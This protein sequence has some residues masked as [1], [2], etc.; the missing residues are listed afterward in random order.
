LKEIFSFM[1]LSSER[2]S[3]IASASLD[4]LEETGVIVKNT[5]AAFFLKEA[6]CTIASGRIL[7]PR[8]LVKECI[9]KVP[10]TF[11][12]FTREG[13]R[14]D[15]VGQDEIIFNPGSAAAYIKN[16]QGRDIRK[17]TLQDMEDLVRVVNHLKYMRAQSTAVIP[18]NVPEHVA[19]LSRLHVI[20]RLSSKPIVTG[21][22]SKSGFHAMRQM[23][24]VVAGGSDEL[25][26]KPRAIFD[27]CPSSPLVW[28]DTTCQNLIDCAKSGIP[29]EIVPAPISGA[30][31]PVSLYGTLIQSNAEILSGVVISQLVKPGSP[32]IYGGAASSMDMKIGLPRFGSVEAV[33]I[34]CGGTELGKSYGFPTHCY[35]GS[36]D[37]KV[38]DSQS[39]FE[40]GLGLVMAAII[41]TNIVSGAGMLAQLNCQSLEKLVIDN[42]ICGSAYRIKR[43]IDSSEAEHMTS[44]IGEVAPAGDYLKSKHTTKKYRTEFFMPSDIISGLGL[45]A[46]RVSGKKS[47]FDRAHEKVASFLQEPLEEPLP[48]DELSRL[49]KILREAENNRSKMAEI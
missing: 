26:K 7:F 20:L 30:T 4:V 11:E 17:A 45:D 49:D 21:A 48:K 27:C 23:L 22:F 3:H 41:G 43:G 34:A 39:G 18:S 8:D 15:L 19:D 38:E 40:S 5:E 12:L 16:H 6:G 46:W 31:S 29:A 24:E 2:L 9:N 10:A 14:S 32:I 33:M 44:L 13:K 47:A 1:F 35:L 36:S 42:E 28:S 25:I 37:S